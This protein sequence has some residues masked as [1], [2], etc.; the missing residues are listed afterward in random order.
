MVPGV[1]IITTGERES[2]GLAGCANAYVAVVKKGSHVTQ[3]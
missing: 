1:A 2:R 3:A